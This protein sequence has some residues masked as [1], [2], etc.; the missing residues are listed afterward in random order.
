M[1]SASGV[2]TTPARFSPL[3]WITLLILVAGLVL[4]SQTLAFYPDEGFHLLAAQLI[5]AGKKPYVDFLYPQTPIWAYVDA[6]WMKIFGDTWRSSHMLAA[7]LTGGSIILSAS[8][9]FERIPESKWRLSAALIVAILIGLDTTVIGFG[10]IGQAY[11]ICLFLTTA[12]FRIAVKG[13]SQ[14]EPSLL[15]WAGLCAGGSAGS[16][17]LS[18]PV[19]PILLVWTAWRSSGRCSTPCIW[20]LVGAGI[21]FLPVV[22]LALLAPYQ[23]LFNTFDYHFF[24]RSISA[25]NL[26]AL[27][28][29]F[30]T[31][32]ELLNSGQ[33]MLQIVFAGMGLLFI[34]IHSEWEAE[35][36][37]EFYLCGLL[38]VGLGLF[39]VAVPATFNQYFVLLVPFVS[40]LAAV[41]LLAAA[42]WLR[43]P[44]RPALLVPAVLALFVGGLPWWLSLQHNRRCC[45]WPKLA[46]VAKAVNYITPPD[47]LISAD[48]YIYFAA[49]R[50][51]PSGLE[52]GDSHKLQLSPSRSASLHVVPR[53]KLYEWIAAG[54]FATVATCAA[55]DDWIDETGVRK[56]YREHT[57]INGC[58]IFWSKVEP[59]TE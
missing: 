33:F 31:L 16:S 24:Y 12:A 21:S 9:V 5:L 39:L 14:K 41:G 1:Q 7:L 11:G 18:A 42:S 13:V 38:A 29:N 35:Q 27:H 57:T 54:R 59:A 40:I 50:T 28:V 32:T 58:D 2:V 22:W 46:E 49:Q 53:A 52:N 6:G 34:L 26:F 56:V 45:T 51:P 3:L 25:D 15:L 10:T 36:K 55:T 8:F 30:R 19:L 37:S 44:G 17:L 48:S 20:F 23:T 43:P 47:G 4:F